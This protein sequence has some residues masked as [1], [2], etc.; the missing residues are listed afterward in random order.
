MLVRK[1]TGATLVIR[2]VRAGI[3]VVVMIEGNLMVMS[4]MMVA[5][6]MCVRVFVGVSANLPRNRRMIL[7]RR[8]RGHTSAT[9][10]ELLS[11]EAGKHDERS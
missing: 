4:V 5:L 1:L 2:S 6:A 8:V 11:E 3:P 10:G 9:A 7:T